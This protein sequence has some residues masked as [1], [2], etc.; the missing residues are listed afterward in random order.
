M[1]ALE[2]RLSCDGDWGI[3][4][5][6]VVFEATGVGP[7]IQGETVE[8]DGRGA[9][10]ASWGAPASKGRSSSVTEA[11][12]FRRAQ[13]KINI[14]KRKKKKRPGGVGATASRTEWGRWGQIHRG[15][16]MQLVSALARTSQ[17][18]RTVTVAA[19]GKGNALGE[20]LSGPRC[21]T[22]VSRDLHIVLGGGR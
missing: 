16:S 18:P 21:L 2:S 12:G 3:D 7:V 10:D 9:E 4:F 15:Q 22:Y 11:G 20:H 5:L 1:E 13:K 17:T 8:D 19:G 6:S 14:G